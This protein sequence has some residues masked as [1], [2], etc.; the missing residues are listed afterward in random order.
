[1]TV[2]QSARNGTGTMIKVVIINMDV[3]VQQPWWWRNAEIEARTLL[4]NAIVIREWP[5]E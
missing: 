1:M 3:V 5:N 2:L 4:R